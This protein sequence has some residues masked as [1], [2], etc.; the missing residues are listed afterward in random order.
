VLNS[1]GPATTVTGANAVFNVA[2]DPLGKYLYVLDT[3]NPAATPAVTGQLYGYNLGTGGV[4]G[5]AIAGTPVATGLGP[6]GIAIDPTSSLIAVDDS[7]SIPGT[8]SLFS[9]G[10]GG[11][12]T[13]D[14][15]VNAGNPTDVYGSNPLFVIFYVAP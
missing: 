9:I 5:A 15:P 1:L 6:T 14:T 10:T 12:L 4:I 11:A 3:G 8:I 13:A 7:F 2:V